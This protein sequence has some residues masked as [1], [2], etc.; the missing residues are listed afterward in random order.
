M[1]LRKLVG[2]MHEEETKYE[3]YVFGGLP[4]FV[5]R[6]VVRAGFFFS[7][8]FLAGGLVWLVWLG[9]FQLFDVTWWHGAAARAFHS[10]KKMF[11]DRNISINSKLKLFE[12]TVTPIAGC[13]AG[14]HSIR[15]T[16]A[17]HNKIGHHL[18]RDFLLRGRLRVLFFEKTEIQH[19]NL[20]QRVSGTNF[21]IYFENGYWVRWCLRCDCSLMR[22]CI[23]SF[24]Q[25]HLWQTV[26]VSFLLHARLCK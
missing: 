21:L 2:N 5:R 17:C 1:E 19:A 26:R 10:N 20:I 13:A 22:L 4:I 24:L 3:P 9:S 15:R 11:W 14:H 8:L 18:H 12:A 7:D 6:P 25:Q 16:P 23:V